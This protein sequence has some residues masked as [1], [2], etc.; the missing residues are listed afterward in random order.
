MIIMRKIV[1][2]FVLAMGLYLT[3]NSSYATSLVNSQFANESKDE[4]IKYE[5]IDE[6]KNVFENDEIDKETVEGVIED[7][8]DNTDDDNL[9][10]ISAL[11]ITKGEFKKS[12]ESTFEDSKS[13]D[14]DGEKGQQI[15]TVIYYYKDTGAIVISNTT[16][17]EIGASGRCETDI[18]LDNI[19]ANNLIIIV[20]DADGVVG[21][22]HYTINK[23]E[24]QIKEQL[25]NH[26]TNFTDVDD[27]ENTI[28]NKSGIRKF[29]E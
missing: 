21:I 15:Y 9:N 4:T 17:K 18:S 23:K 16:L 19:G 25:E 5:T 26:N 3:S 27:K 8:K 12:E 11:K 14:F 24:S 2:L 7:A 1:Y 29:G 6:Y 10:V 20:G 13:I 22:R 28:K